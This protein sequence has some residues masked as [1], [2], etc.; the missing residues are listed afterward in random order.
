MQQKNHTRTNKSRTEATRSALICAA[1]ALF[2]EKGYA[3]TSTPEIAE[4]AGVTRGALYHHFQDKLAVFRAV[5]TEEYMAVADEIAASAE[6]APGSAI[7]ALQH[8]SRG[9]LRAM[10]DPG[11]V[12]IMLL[13]GP[14]VL[15]QIELNKI[16]HETSA[17]TLRLGLTEA[18][19][20]KE[21][22]KLPIEAL[23]TQ[24]SALFDRAALAVSQ[25]DSQ[26]DHLEVLDSILTALAQTQPPK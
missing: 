26:A 22:K 2:A 21:I 13:D 5:I 6:A 18:M 25:G 15:G 19:Q 11:R 17:G 24:L 20:S 7:A 1:R 16:D 8:G 10:D 9:Y 3:E 23:T 4:T 14:A 12:R